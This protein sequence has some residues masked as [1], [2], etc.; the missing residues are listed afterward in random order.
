MSSLYVKTPKG[1]AEIEHR[2]HGV[3]ARQRKLLILID[4]KR[5]EKDLAAMFPGADASAILASLL[6]EG[7]VKLLAPAPPPAPQPVAQKS[8]APKSAVPQPVAPKS[9]APQP[10]APRPVAPRAM[11][12]NE[13]ER[14]AQARQF[15][16]STTRA[17]ISLN[18]PSLINQLGESVS[19][20]SH[21]EACADLDA[22]REQLNPWREVLKLS[23]EGRK[24][25]AD[26]EKKLVPLLA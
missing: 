17:H 20:I 16:I 13:A 8:V 15:M 7:Y 12:G 6:D 14:F 24:D 5:D 26:L 3:S 22:L 11:T 19:L 2:S 23:R 4:G 18:D 21:L 10:I 1:I 25:M 9:V